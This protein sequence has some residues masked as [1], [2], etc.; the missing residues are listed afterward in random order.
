MEDNCANS[1]WNSSM[2]LVLWAGSNLTFMCDLYLGSTWT[3]VSN[4][5]STHERKQFCKFVLKSIQNCRSCALELP[6]QM[7]QMAH[8]H[9]MENNNL[10]CQII[11]KS[12]HNCRSY[13]PD[14]FWRMHTLM[15][16]HTPNYH[17][18]NYVL[19]TP[20]GVK[21]MENKG[22]NHAR[23]LQHCWFGICQKADFLLWT[24]FQHFVVIAVL[25]HMYQG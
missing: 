1:Y 10:L 15:H 21:K 7:F 13:G 19:L 8:L 23:W 20:T 17:C 16:K 3:N 12:T 22:T 9:M 4:G 5:T 2:I 25:R 6:E 11:L 18:D 14:K 24:V